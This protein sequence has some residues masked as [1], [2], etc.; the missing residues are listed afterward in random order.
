MRSDQVVPALLLIVVLVV[1]GWVIVRFGGSQ[2]GAVPTDIESRNVTELTFIDYRGQEL[3][4]DTFD[5]V[6]VRIVNTWGTWSS[7]SADELAAFA[8]LEE[9]FGDQVVVIAVNRGETV[10]Q[11]RAFTDR[12][13]VTNSIVPVLDREDTFYQAIDGFTM[14]ETIFLDHEG[15]IVQHKRGSMSLSEM[16]SRVN[17]VLGNQPAA[18]PAE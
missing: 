17:R 9:E 10:E 7:S 11:A 2:N 1:I 13:G 16:Q 18:V 3:T 4:L 5:Q 8:L 14:P 12:L 6:P 15:S